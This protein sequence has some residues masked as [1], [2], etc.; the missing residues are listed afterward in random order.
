MFRCPHLIG[1]AI[2]RCLVK[3]QRRFNRKV[4]EKEYSKWIVTLPPEDVAA[5][6]WKE[7]AELE[8]DVKNDEL[9][10]RR[11]KKT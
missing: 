4:N 6:G 11:R 1:S 2:T 5:V 10:I 9:V 8:I 3:L 7:G